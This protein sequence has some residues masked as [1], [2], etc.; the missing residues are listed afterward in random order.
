MFKGV[1][2]VYWEI[3]KKD[4]ED[5]QDSLKLD[6]F[7]VI[8][9]FNPESY[10]PG[11]L[12]DAYCYRGADGCLVAFAAVQSGETFAEITRFYTLVKYRRT[13]LGKKFVQALLRLLNSNGVQEVGVEYFSAEGAC[14]WFSLGFKPISE[15]STRLVI[16][17]NEHS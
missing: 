14:F 2:E 6:D 7:E 8:R 9:R 11:M 10:E 1:I 12:H 3:T 16:Q 17:L 5:I 15:G 13:G 4:Q